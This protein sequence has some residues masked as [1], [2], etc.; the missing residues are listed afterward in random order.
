MRATNVTG[1]CQGNPPGYDIWNGRLLGGRPSSWHLKEQT[2]AWTDEERER[3]LEVLGELPAILKD[4]GID[5]IY[6]LKRAI[7]PENPA[8]NNFSSVVLYDTAFEK[9]YNLAH[10]LAHELSHRLYGSLSKREKDSFRIAGKW[11]LTKKNTYEVGRPQSEFLRPNGMLSPEEDFCDTIPTY[12]L[13][14]NKL[15]I[16]SP[17][18]FNWVDNHVKVWSAK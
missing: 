4:E 9:D 10:V 18:L 12:F 17:R 2:S 14:P 6:R 7:I 16:L 5:G 11:K 3:V 13:Q 1:H 8:S 15:K